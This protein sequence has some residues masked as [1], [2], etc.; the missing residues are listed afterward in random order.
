MKTKLAKIPYFLM[1]FSVALLSDDQI[2]LNM[3]KIQSVESAAKT[4]SV[5]ALINHPNWRGNETLLVNEVSCKGSDAVKILL[6]YGDDPNQTNQYGETLLNITGMNNDLPIVKLL[7]KH[8]ANPNQIDVFGKTSLRYPVVKG[9]SNI[10]ALLLKYGGKA[11]ARFRGKTLLMA[12]VACGHVEIAKLLIRNG[13]DVNASRKLDT[14]TELIIFYNKAELEAYQKC[15]G[16]TALMEATS[17]G[18]LEIV[19]LLIESGADIHQKSR[20]GSTAFDTGKGKF[21]MLIGRERKE[22]F[23]KLNPHPKNKN[24]PNQNNHIYEKY[25]TSRLHFTKI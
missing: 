5:K 1:V 22:I 16:R 20:D 25:L 9:N 13:A 2:K 21:D 4:E 12:T 6:E 10:L 19:N 17:G 15:H 14:L 7:L 23:T 24:T 3:T 8:G 11:N 18:H